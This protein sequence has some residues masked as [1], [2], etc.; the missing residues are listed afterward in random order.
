MTDLPPDVIRILSFHGLADLL[1]GPEGDPALERVPVAPFEDLVYA[2]VRQGGATEAAL[3]SSN[4][5]EL[6]ARAM[7]GSYSLRL[8]GRAQAG[9]LLT[10]EPNRGALEPW[11]PE[12]TS[13]AG[14]LAVPFATYRIEFV[15][16]EGEER[17]RYHGPTPSGKARQGTLVEWG[18][19]CFPLSSRAGLVLA[20]AAPWIYMGLAGPEQAW[21][22]LALALSFV[23][24][25]CAL[26]GTRLLCLNLAFH[27]WREGRA[28]AQDARPLCDAWIAPAEARMVGLA[29]LVLFLG[30]TW[31]VQIGWDSSFAWLTLLANG[32][33]L[34]GPG[35]VF[36]L[37]SGRETLGN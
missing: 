24:G 25:A 8:L 6:H 36:H 7:D 4:R 13:K 1:V 14:L 35:W 21:R 10:R 17:I 20:F 31:V 2:F 32:A 9:R 27:R 15:R 23:A 11:L 12:G 22:L 37:Q 33:W 16:E 34:L 18:R 19:A 30:L 3:L 26:S 28:N 5:A 29:L